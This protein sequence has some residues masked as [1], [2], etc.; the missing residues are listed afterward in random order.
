[1]FSRVHHIFLH[2]YEDILSSLVLMSYTRAR[3]VA[4]TSVLPFFCSV[5]SHFV[6]ELVLVFLVK[7]RLRQ[8]LE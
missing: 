4:R 6:L 8:I 7:T 2:Q 3:H 5:I 1:M